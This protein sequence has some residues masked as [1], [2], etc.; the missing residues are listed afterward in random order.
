MIGH[1]SQTKTPEP[2]ELFLVHF[3]LPPCR[4]LTNFFKV[5]N[6]MKSVPSIPAAATPFT[7]TSWPSLRD[8]GLLALR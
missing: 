6:P 2:S 7:A 1:L 3:D 5:T 4:Y 8:T